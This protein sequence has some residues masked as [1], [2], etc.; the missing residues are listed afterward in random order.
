MPAKEAC[1]R[2]WR[3]LLFKNLKPILSILSIFHHFFIYVRLC[4][5]HCQLPRW[6]SWLDNSKVP[7]D[8]THNCC[9]LW[10]LLNLRKFPAVAPQGSLLKLMTAAPLSNEQLQSAVKPSNYSLLQLLPKS[11]IA[12]HMLKQPPAASWSI[13]LYPSLDILSSVLIM[14]SA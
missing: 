3:N 14:L 9:F 1:G 2:V 13:F 5:H 6:W 12:S 7:Y 11:P 10:Q 8:D 4:F